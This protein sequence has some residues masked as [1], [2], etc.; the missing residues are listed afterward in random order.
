MNLV[1]LN[2]MLPGEGGWI[3]SYQEPKDLHHRLKELGLV[4][5]TRLRVRRCAPLGDP[6]ELSIRGYHLSIRKEDARHILVIKDG[7][8]LC[9]CENRRGHHG[10]QGWC[11]PQHIPKGQR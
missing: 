1:T 11:G 5:G 3:H 6:M 8:G 2:R 10:G 9:G 7:Q 4:E